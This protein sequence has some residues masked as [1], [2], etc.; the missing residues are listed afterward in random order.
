MEKV[1]DDRK[2]WGERKARQV[3]KSG[4]P[5]FGKSGSPEVGKKFLQENDSASLACLVP[6]ISYRVS[7]ILLKLYTYSNSILQSFYAVLHSFGL[8]D[9]S[10]FRTCRLFKRLNLPQS[11][12]HRKRNPLLL[13]V[14]PMLLQFFYEGWNGILLVMLNIFLCG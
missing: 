10:D 14:V 13:P 8:P 2:D 3:G 7:L 5:K 12:K 9:F 1:Y 11:H 4:S 6:K